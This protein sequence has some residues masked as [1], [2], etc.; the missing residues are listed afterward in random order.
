MWKGKGTKIT[1]TVFKN[2]VGGLTLLDVR[3]NCKATVIK[4]DQWNKRENTE[5]DAHIH[6]PSVFYKVAKAIQWKK[7]KFY[8]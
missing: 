1:K 2:K 4:I 5:V 8:S 7:K 6:I 3:L